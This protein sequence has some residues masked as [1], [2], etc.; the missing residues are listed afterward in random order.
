MGL[1]RTGLKTALPVSRLGAALFA[2]RHRKEIFGWA[3]FVQ[4]AAPDLVRGDSADVLVEARLRARLTANSTT[5]DAEGLRVEVEDGVATLSGVV[6]HKV[7]DAALAVATNT[8]GI[9]R[10]KDELGD[11]GR[12]WGASS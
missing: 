3:Q 2:W 6:D 7:H 1:L 5:R 4:R 11:L 10:V 8:S 12:R 9:D